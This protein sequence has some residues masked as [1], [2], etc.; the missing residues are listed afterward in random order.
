MP[1]IAFI[2]F[3]TAVYSSPHLGQLVDAKPPPE[4]V[5]W[6]N[7]P[8]TC[9]CMSQLMRAPLSEVSSRTPFSPNRFGTIV[10]VW[11]S[12]AAACV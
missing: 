3:H 1:N 2:L 6:K 4:G 9:V 7:V 8:Y 10:G 11:T 12:S 5:F